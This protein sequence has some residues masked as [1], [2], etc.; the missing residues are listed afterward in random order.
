M[1]RRATS[2]R[3]RALC[4]VPPPQMAQVAPP[5]SATPPALTAPPELMTPAAPATPATPVAPATP[6]TSVAPVAPVARLASAPR[7]TWGLTALVRS[8]P[9]SPPVRR[10]APDR[11]PGPAPPARPPHMRPP[12]RAARDRRPRGPPSPPLRRPDAA[13]TWPAR[14]PAARR[15]RGTAHRSARPPTRSRNHG[16]PVPRPAVEVSASVPAFARHARSLRHPHGLAM[17]LPHPLGLATSLP[18]PHGPATSLLHPHRLLG[19]RHGG[20]LQGQGERIRAG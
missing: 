4:P 5:Q 15:R 16:R 19:E 12:G 8:H 13:P 3:A 9:R 1:R 2:P 20:R 17:S 18:H 14:R 10:T 7:T 6:A 11:P